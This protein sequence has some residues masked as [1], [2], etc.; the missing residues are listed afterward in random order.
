MVLASQ[1]DIEDFAD[2]VRAEFGNRLEE[3]IL[4]GSYARDDHVPGSDIDM[5]VLVTRKN[6]DDRQKLFDITD[7]FREEKGL[8]FSPRVFEKNDFT[9]KAENG[10]RF[11]TN[12]ENEG[13]EI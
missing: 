6:N 9:E 1:K 10:W 13:V 2:Q 4:Y 8:N 7:K 3:V 11:H 12:V 5:A